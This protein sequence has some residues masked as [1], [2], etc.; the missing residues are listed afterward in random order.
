MTDYRRNFIPG[1]SYF[2]TVAVASVARTKCN[3]IRENLGHVRQ[4]PDS[5]TLHPGYSKRRAG[6][7]RRCTIGDAEFCEGF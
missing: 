4:H 5:A 1:G 3:G 6:H 2:F 7:T